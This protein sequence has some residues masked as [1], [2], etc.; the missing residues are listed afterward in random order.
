MSPKRKQR[1]R[2]S[3]QPAEKPKR[4]IAAIPKMWKIAI[5][6]VGIPGL[7]ASVLSVLPRVSVTP[8]ENI[9][10][11]DPLL[12]PFVISN[13]GLLDIHSVGFLCIVDYLGTNR[14]IY[15]ENTA[16]GGVNEPIG[17]LGAGGRTTTI[18]GSLIDMT[19]AG[20]YREA[21]ITIQIAFRPDFLPWK[22]HRKFPFRGRLDDN[23]VIHW[24]PA[25]R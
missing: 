17:D 12:A 21:H 16:V 2:S 13:D 6:L 19:S 20:D 8:E 7:Y 11:A 14:D 24:F 18:C 3:K 1:N 23:R 10:P 22:T 5:F 15:M 9:H 4:W 25:S